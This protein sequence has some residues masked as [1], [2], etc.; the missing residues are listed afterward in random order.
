[1]NKNIQRVQMYTQYLKFAFSL[2][3]V[4]MQTHPHTYTHVIR[5]TLFKIVTRNK[6]EIYIMYIKTYGLNHPLVSM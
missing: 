2:A 4:I 5:E 3:S 6:I 1:M